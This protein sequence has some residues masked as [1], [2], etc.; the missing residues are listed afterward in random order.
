MSEE[1]STISVKTT[2]EEVSSHKLKHY[3]KE[4]YKKIGGLVKQELETTK[5]KRVLSKYTQDRVSR[6][7]ENPY[8]YEKDIRELVRFLSTSSGIFRRV[9]VYMSTLA[10]Y[11]Y[12]ITPTFKDF[13]YTSKDEIRNQMIEVSSLLEKMNLSHELEKIA[14][15]VFR[16]DVFY[17]YEY[18]TNNSYSIGQL[19][20]DYCRISGIVDGTYVYDFDFKYFDKNKEILK[21]FPSEFKV[22]YNLYQEDRTLDW[23]QISHKKSVCIKLNDDLG[24]VFPPFALM[25]E[26]IFDLDD[27]KQLDKDRAKLDNYM[28]LIHQIPFDDKSGEMDKFLINPDTASVFH[29]QI[30]GQL[31]KE[32]ALTT[33]PMKMESIKLEKTNNDKDRIANATRGAYD[34]AGVSQFLFNSDKNTSIGLRKSIMTDEQIV[35]SLLRQMERWVNRKLK[36]TYKNPMFKFSFLDSTKQNKETLQK[37]ILDLGKYGVPVRFELGAL[38]GYSPLSL[39]NKAYLESEVLGLDELFVPLS[40]SHTTSNKEDD[41]GRPTK[42]DDSISDSGQTNKDNDTNEE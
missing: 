1:L 36:I 27:Y 8:A 18:E 6:M 16:E 35:F 23:Q 12:T 22:K 31:P 24:V 29:S 2:N 30:E 10:N 4:F 5:N 9:I 20:S 14:K 38:M 25:I 7:L 39:L 37:E 11:H 40:S 19:D 28:I 15:V 17:G 13:I 42:D 21:S 3:A 34:N 41:K 26:S 32:I 33:T